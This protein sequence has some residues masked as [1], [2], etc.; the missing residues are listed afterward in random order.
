M[1]GFAKNLLCLSLSL[2]H[3]F[4]SLIWFLFCFC[5]VCGFWEFVGILLRVEPDLLVFIWFSSRI[6]RRRREQESLEREDEWE[7]KRN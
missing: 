1:E 7:K 6:S 3:G 2:S 5:S 4:V